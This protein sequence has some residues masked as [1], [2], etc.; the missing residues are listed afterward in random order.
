M[1]GD[2]PTVERPC[3]EPVRSLHGDTLLT[4]TD[5]R[6]ILR[7]LHLYCERCVMA[8]LRYVR[9]CDYNRGQIRMHCHAFG[10]YHVTTL[11]GNLCK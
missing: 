8:V 5:Y 3:A 6:F 10:C 11:T 1:G 2:R 4:Y 9:T 7:Q